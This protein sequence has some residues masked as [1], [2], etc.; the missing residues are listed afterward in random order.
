MA[1]TMSVIMSISMCEDLIMV[2][3]MVLAIVIM[4]ADIVDL[5]DFS[6]GL[7][8]HLT[9]ASTCWTW[10]VFAIVYSLGRRHVRDQGR[11]SRK[12]I[13]FLL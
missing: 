13:E 7:L 5:L 10:T 1:M 6:F 3:V 12:A 4:S 2:M 9:R 8:F 11:R